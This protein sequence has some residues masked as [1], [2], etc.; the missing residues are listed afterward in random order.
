MTILRWTFIKTV[1]RSIFLWLESVAQFIQW[2][3][4]SIRVKFILIKAKLTRA[5]SSNSPGQL[6]GQGLLQHCT[7]TLELTS[8]I[9]QTNPQ[10]H[11]LPAETQNSLV[12]ACFPLSWQNLT[13][14][15]ECFSFSINGLI[16]AVVYY[17]I[18]Y[19]AV[20]WADIVEGVHVYPWYVFIGMST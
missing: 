4:V 18:I 11:S 6:R 10:H 2:H 5:S 1:H 20:I 7:K 19:N 9:P 12:L 13:G 14:A 8:G 3:T 15:F 17:Y 16:N